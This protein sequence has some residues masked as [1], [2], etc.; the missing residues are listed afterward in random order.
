MKNIKIIAD[1]VCDLPEDI[2]KKYDIDI[3]PLTINFDNQSFRDGVDLE[4]RELFQLLNA[5]TKLPTT[6]QVSP[7][8]FIKAFESYKDYKSAI[9]ITMSSKLSGTYQ[10]AL[11]AKEQLSK[12]DISVVDSQ[13]IT[14]G[15]GLL[16][17]RAAKMASEGCTKEE[18]VTSIETMKQNIKYLFV[19]DTLE[20]LKK[21]G[22]LSATKAA[23]G[24]ILN[25][26]PVLTMDD[27]YLVPYN[28]VRT[29][30]KVIPWIIEYLKKTGVDFK[31][32]SIGVNHADDLESA[33]ELIEEIKKNFEVGEIILSE[34]GC[35][36]SVHSG[37]GAVAIYYEK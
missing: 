11:L 21:G 25:I 14:L 36:V 28:K 30:K 31:G 8:E 32:K 9:V 33:L 16:V 29:K 17:Y 34:T 5:S 2:I 37:P 20:Y 3:Q 35:T 22:R 6:S 12:L 1:S 18:I 7:G 27:G 23:L 4:T 19:V 10:S 13:G 24:T 15:Y 26:K